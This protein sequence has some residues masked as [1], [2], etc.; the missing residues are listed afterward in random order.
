MEQGLKRIEKVIFH[1][2]SSYRLLWILR[3]KGD[4]MAKRRVSMGI[5]SR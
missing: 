4:G 2:S 1:P 3:F 5:S